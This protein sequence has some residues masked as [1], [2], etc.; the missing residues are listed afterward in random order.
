MIEESRSA[1]FA[2]YSMP[3]LVSLDQVESMERWALG[4][5][6]GETVN[7]G[8]R[9]QYSLDPS[10]LYLLVHGQVVCSDIVDAYLKLIE[11]VGNDIRWTHIQST[12]LPT[13]R[14]SNKTDFVVSMPASF[15]RNNWPNPT[16]RGMTR[17]KLSDVDFADFLKIEILLVPIIL[18]HQWRLLVIYPRRR[19]MRLLDS[20]DNSSNDTAHTV[21]SLHRVIRPTDRTLSPTPKNCLLSVITFLKLKYGDDFDTTQWNFDTTRSCTQRNKKDSG[22]F[23]IINSELTVRALHPDVA[24]L[25]ANDDHRSTTAAEH[26]RSLISLRLGIARTIDRAV[27]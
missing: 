16:N 21:T 15:F 26:Q 3:H 10:H 17:H 27:I 25:F 9:A 22:V 8:G 14:P 20:S 18:D 12:N 5:R 4:I 7:T 24:E 1:L 23:A 13:L 19:T 11:I 6:G 2:V